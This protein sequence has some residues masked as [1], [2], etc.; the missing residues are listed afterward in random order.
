[1]EPEACSAAGETKKEGWT[2]TQAFLASE[3]SSLGVETTSAARSSIPV[4]LIFLAICSALDRQT[5]R[6]PSRA[7]GTPLK[8]GSFYKAY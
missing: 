5:K 7:F 4:G 8:R 2:G 1:M 6:R 3:L